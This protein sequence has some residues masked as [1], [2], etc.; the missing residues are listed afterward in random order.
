MTK[1]VCTWHDDEKCGQVGNDFVLPRVSFISFLRSST[2]I[3]AIHSQWT[4]HWHQHQHQSFTFCYVSCW[5][6]DDR[7]LFSYFAELFSYSRV[8][9][10]PNY[11]WPKSS[12]C[13]RCRKVYGV[14][15]LAE[16]LFVFVS[17]SIFLFVW[18]ISQ[19]LSISTVSISV[20]FS[21]FV[22]VSA[23]VKCSL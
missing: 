14:K 21:R 23:H 22:M 15:T 12:M 17:V 19:F 13:V 10:W 4:L 5:V 2:I 8:V 3:L 11:S 9:L 20:A 6:Y 18:L 7:R 1:S 16:C